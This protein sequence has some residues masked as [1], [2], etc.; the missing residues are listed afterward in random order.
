MGD[1]YREN[2]SILLLFWVLAR[3]T[4]TIK[5]TV[6]KHTTSGTEHIHKGIQIS[7]HLLSEL[8]PQTNKEL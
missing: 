5:L 8:L 6:G 1:F 2:I 7:C 3:K 4:H